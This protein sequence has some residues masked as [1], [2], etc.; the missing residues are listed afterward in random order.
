MGRRFDAEPFLRPLTG[1]QRATVDHVT[2]RL[3]GAG[4]SRRFLV[5][6]E[7][8]LGKSLVARGVVART[9]EHLQ[10]DPSVRRI[11]VVYVCSSADLAQQ[12]I[13]RLD[14]TGIR[15]LPIASRLTLLA[16]HAH[17]LS[18]RRHQFV[19]PV[20]LVSFTPGTSFEMGWQTGT[21]QERALLYLLVRGPLDLTGSQDTSARRLLQG[22]VKNL[23]TFTAEVVR[24]EQ[25]LGGPVDRTIS[26]RFRSIAQRSGSL[27]EFASLVEQMGR[28]HKV[29]GSLGDQVRTVIGRM[30]GDLARAGVETL[31]PDLVIL[32]EF[33]RFRHLLHRGSG[34]PAAELAHSLFDYGNAKVLLLSATPYKPFTYAEEAA[35]G[36]DHHSD[37]VRT[38]E[39]L[40]EGCRDVSVDAIAKDLVAYRHAAITGGSLTEPGGRLREQLLKV[41]CR[42]ERPDTDDVRMVREICVP[43]EPVRAE[44]MA[45]YVRLRRVAQT[46]DGQLT[47]DYW[48]SAPYFINFMDGYRLADKVRVALADPADRNDLMP[49][50]REVQQ[51]EPRD[52]RGFRPVDFGNAR[53]RVLAADTVEAGWWT[54]LWI[55]PSLTYLTPAGPYAEP[56]ARDVTKRLVFSSWTAT[57]T[58]VAALLSYD[59]ERRIAAGSPL[60]EN[61]LRARRR[62]AQRLAYSLEGRRPQAMTTLMLFWPNPGLAR[63]TDPLTH[64]RRHPAGPPVAAEV[65]ADVAADLAPRLPAGRTSRATSAEAWYWI[66]PLRMADALPV[67]F[68]DGFDRESADNS[69]V[70]TLVAALG[71]EELT[72]DDEHRSDPVGLTA[73]VELALRTYLGSVD[74]AGQPADLAETVGAIGLHGPGNIAWRALGRLLNERSEVTSRGHWIAAAALSAGLRSLFGRLETVLLLDRQTDDRPY[75]RKVLQYCADGNLQA[76]LDEHLH[77]LAMAE[78]ITQLTDDCLLTLARTVADS[79][80]LRPSRYTAFDPKRPDKPIPLTS[81][82]ALRYGGRRQN[83]ESSRQPEIRRAFNSPFWP[84]VLATTSVGQEG[85][86]FH[87]WSHAVFHWNTPTN[88]VDFE[89]REGRVYRYAGHAVRRNIATRHRVAILASGDPDPWSAAYGLATDEIKRLGEFSPHW[90]YPGEAKI[91]RIIAPYPLSVDSTRLERLK[92]DLALYRLTFGQPRQ[93]DML[94]L[95]RRHGNAANGEAGLGLRPPRRGSGAADG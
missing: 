61:T 65:L 37:F 70:T 30:R 5:A 90:V 75:W 25:R 35:A 33:Q 9:I 46:V 82:F 91:L 17:S 22:Q 95:L 40:A 15:G 66:A 89:Q 31:S 50:V 12:N 57:P 20:N 87:W 60:G 7:T 3:Y 2:D 72:V 24:V 1:F 21:V 94:G 64:A 56:F 44:D 88:P 73:H 34:G 86:D 80:A 69:V 84:F 85:L 13:R 32:D 38:L 83:E 67:E 53:M 68:I 52:L 18:K 74:V 81:R 47:L 4:S 78:G 23:D 62:I 48:K 41:M 45:D 63:Q 27:R 11:N 49:L 93:E 77:H 10:D 28:R 51:I 58:A 92:D 76:V 54:L 79:I 55:P 36:D 19:K 29:P 42:S 8:G 16:T 71:G 26:E 59:A 43:A 39:F 14:V 6:D